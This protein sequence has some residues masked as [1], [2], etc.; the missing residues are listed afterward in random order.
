MT[1]VQTCALPICCSYW[2]DNLGFFLR[3]N[4]QLTTSYLPLGV[5]QRTC[6]SRRAVAG[7]LEALQQTATVCSP[8]NSYFS[9]AVAG[10]TSVFCKGSFTLPI[11]LLFFV[12]L[13]LFYFILFAFNYQKH[14]KISYLH[15]VYF[16]FSFYYF[17]MLL[18]KY[19]LKEIS[20]G[21]GSIIGR[22]IGRASCRERVLRLV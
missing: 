11:S 6:V 9:G 15:L 14:K 8:V 18:P 22:E 13:S 2:F 21:S 20:V 5:S 17:I 12:L 1:G 10:E 7:E 16:S 3:E 19:T 4:L